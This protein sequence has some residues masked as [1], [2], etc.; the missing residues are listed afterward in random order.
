MNDDPRTD[1]Q[2][3]S[4]DEVRELFEKRR[5]AATRLRDEFGIDLTGQPGFKDVNLTKEPS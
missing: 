4:D 5:T 2:K 3:K 1:A